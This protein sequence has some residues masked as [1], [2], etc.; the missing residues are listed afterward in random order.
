VCVLGGRVNG[1]PNRTQLA[2]SPLPP[3]SRF[4]PYT[5]T[6]HLLN[7][8]LVLSPHEIQCLFRDKEEGG[9]Q[10]LAPLFPL[11]LPLR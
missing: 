5:F 2:Q 1:D 3:K 6:P 4:L 10:V 9:K 7:R 8:G 11:Q